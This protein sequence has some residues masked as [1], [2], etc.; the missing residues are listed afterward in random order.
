MILRT[1]KKHLP[2]TKDGQKLDMDKILTNWTSNSFASPRISLTKFGQKIDHSL[3][4]ICPIWKNL[5]EGNTFRQ[6]LDNNGKF[7]TKYGQIFDKT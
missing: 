5:G 2:K 4:I 7:W 1:M 6:I 3:S